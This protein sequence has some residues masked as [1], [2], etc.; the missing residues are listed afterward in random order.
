MAKTSFNTVCGAIESLA[1]CDGEQAA[2]QWIGGF[3][4]DRIETAFREDGFTMLRDDFKAAL[5]D[6][7]ESLNRTTP[8]SHDT[9]RSTRKGWVTGLVLL[10]GLCLVAHSPLTIVVGLGLLISLLAR[11]AP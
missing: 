9:R 11:P 7:L 5:A 10:F 2:I 3:G 6:R 1:D 8:H 4:I